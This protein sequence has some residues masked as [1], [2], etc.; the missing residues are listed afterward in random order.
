MPKHCA[1]REDLR[2]WCNNRQIG[3]GWMDA[4]ESLLAGRDRAAAPCL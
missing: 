4:Q 1:V 3:V 2:L